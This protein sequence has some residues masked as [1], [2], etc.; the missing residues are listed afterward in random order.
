[1]LRQFFAATLCFLLL[2][3]SWCAAQEMT[4]ELLEKIKA[5]AVYIEMKMQQ[6]T[7]SG[8]GWI[9][10]KDAKGALIVTNRHVVTDEEGRKGDDISCIF[11]PGTDKEK[12][13]KA[14][15]IVIDPD[16]DLAV[17]RVEDPTLPDARPIIADV[18]SLFETMKCYTIGFPVG[19]QLSFGKHAPEVAV[20][21]TTISSLRRDDLK[22]LVRIT[23]NGAVTHGNSGGMTVNAKGE[24]VGVVVAM[25]RAA[26][27]I[28]FVIPISQVTSLFNGKPSQ[29]I[30]VPVPSTD[31]TKLVV[32]FYVNCFDPKGGVSQLEF[33]HGP[34]SVIQGMQPD[35]IAMSRA[36]VGGMNPPI[37]M[38]YD[39]SR[40]QGA[41]RVVFNAAD[42]VNKDI[43]IQ[44]TTYRSDG[45]KG[46]TS[47]VAVRVDAKQ[48]FAFSPG[49]KESV[50][51]AASGGSRGV[52]SDTK[53]IKMNEP[54]TDM[55]SAGSG[56]Y[57][58]I[59]AKGELAVVDLTRRERVKTINLADSSLIAG[60]ANCFV[61]YNSFSTKFE[62]WSL[63]SMT[64]VFEAPP[65]KDLKPSEI[66]L[67][68]SSNG[69]LFVYDIPRVSGSS[70]KLSCAFLDLEAFKGKTEM[71]YEGNLQSSR[72]GDDGLAELLQTQIRAAGNGSCFTMWRPL[73]TPQGMAVFRNKKVNK[74]LA[75]DHQEETGLYVV[76]ST[77]GE[78]I[79]TALGAKSNDLKHDKDRGIFLPCTDTEHILA[80]SKRG[81]DLRS[82]SSGATVQSFEPVFPDIEKAP[83]E[84]GVIEFFYS[85]DKRLVCSP[86]YD[87]MA[88]S[89]PGSDTVA[90]SKLGL[91][92]ISPPVAAA[93]V[94]GP[95][96]KIPSGVMRTWTDITGAHQ[97][98]A[99]LVGVSPAGVELQLEANNSQRTIPFEKLSEADARYAKAEAAKQPAPK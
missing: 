99:K 3:S 53:P 20:T 37:Q 94:A 79:C 12:S 29:V 62:K 88:I 55:I 5:S 19:S 44:V 21:E 96:V 4:R 22:R 31:P 15:V 32:D 76:P 42:I 80:L 77:D 50:A 78:T 51:M 56:R 57:L 75:I 16:E 7:A 71:F 54:V 92:N 25:L 60:G 35:Q 70:T 17:L 38:K 69:P 83:S 34:A 43:V 63:D 48:Q 93:P 8:S 95:T 46:T 91:K 40:A 33:H 26:N 65:P 59:R 72:G 68:H 87:V 27:N 45:L 58:L 1:M 23:I 73:T 28:A 64:K 9:I 98:R 86:H 14:T 6:G 82:T 97:T 13:Y 41:C 90:L 24:V 36:P 11:H 39:K 2:G 18:N 67:G 52:T 66:A 84:K 47:P 49:Y 74:K 81:L 89:F 30:G 10:E 85:L 61:I